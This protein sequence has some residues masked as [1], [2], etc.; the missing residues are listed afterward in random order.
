[1]FNRRKINQNWFIWLN[2][3]LMIWMNFV[4]TKTHPAPNFKK[5]NYNFLF[6]RNIKN[7][8]CITHHKVKTSVKKKQNG[9]EKFQNDLIEK[10]Q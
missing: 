5:R 1:M 7:L 2:K 6:Q 3:E 9:V 4:L 8:H 10:N